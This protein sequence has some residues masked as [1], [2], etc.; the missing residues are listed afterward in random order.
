MKKARDIFILSIIVIALFLPSKQIQAQFRQSTTINLIKNPSF[1]LGNILPDYWYPDWW[2]S[3]A[4]YL[5]DD[6]ESHHDDK[7]IKIIATS[8]NDVRWIQRV[9]VQPNTEYI[10]S[11][12]IKTSDV[13]HTSDSIDAGAN[14]CVYGTWDRTTG[15]F[16]NNDWTF[17]SM[18]FNSG[19]NTSIVI[20]ARLGFWSGTTTGS[21]WFDEITLTPVNSQPSTDFNIF[22]PI[23]NPSQC[24]SNNPSW[25]ILVLVY[26]NTD[27]TFTDNQGQ[28]HHFIAEMNPLEK[29]KIEYAILRFTK[30]DI[31]TLTNCNMIPTLTIRYVSHS[32]SSL[33]TVS[34]NDFAPSPW[35]ISE[36]L[37]PG[38][39]SV[40]TIWDGSGKDTITGQ[41]LSIAGCAYAWGMGRGQTYDAIYVDAVHYIERNVF[42]HEWGHSI[43]FYYD[44]V[45]TAPK[46]AVDN[47]INDTTNNYVNCLTGQ[48]YIF[49]DETDVNPIPNSIYN[50]LLGFTHD[51]YSGKT[52]KIDNPTKCLGITSSAW[53]S[54]GPVTN[55]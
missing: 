4:E 45:G 43:L 53:A 35:D 24:V 8:P 22:L 32:L 20:G 40:I 6:N 9:S 42:K 13:A 26:E 19:E 25:K 52:A 36:D 29:Q 37:D 3:S 28:L 12:W 2:D 38:F 33:S 11:G 14:L 49:E 18:T 48:S 21:A 23:I 27:F 46:P 16:G 17:V 31:P 50:N 41:D 1:K 5:W 54:G 30:E 44:A 15:L 47:H 55:H 34:C 39:D 10:L 51:Y 7:S